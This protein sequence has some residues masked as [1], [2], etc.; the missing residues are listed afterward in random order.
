[1][2]V[3]GTECV[4]FIRTISS[5]EEAFVIAFASV[6]KGLSDEPLFSSLPVGET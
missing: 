1:M 6:A 5:S 3:A 2:V 4:P